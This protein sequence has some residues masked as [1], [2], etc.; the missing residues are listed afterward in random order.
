MDY[1]LE[2]VERMDDWGDYP[3]E[4]A[5]RD[6]LCQFAVWDLTQCPEDATICRDLFNIFN[7]EDAL[8]TGIKIAKMGYDRVVLKKVD[9]PDYL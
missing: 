7:Y 8:N 1:E 4:Q 3:E 5:T 6:E 9:D 2:Y